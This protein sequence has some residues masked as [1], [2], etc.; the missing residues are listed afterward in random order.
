MFNQIKVIGK[1][2]GW[3][4]RKRI[5]A[6]EGEKKTLKNEIEKLE[7]LIKGLPLLLSERKAYK[8]EI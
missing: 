2:E 1:V 5:E 8:R 7:D 4:C 3:G 6:L